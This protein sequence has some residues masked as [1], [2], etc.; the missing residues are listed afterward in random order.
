MVAVVVLVQ[1]EVKV[2]ATIGEIDDGQERFNA[3]SATMLV[4]WD[5]HLRRIPQYT[6]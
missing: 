5:R 4:L 3:A 2:K 6:V 1:V